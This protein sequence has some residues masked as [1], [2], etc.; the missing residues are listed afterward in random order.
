[1]A[2]SS[3]E[4]ADKYRDTMLQD[5]RSSGSHKIGLSAAAVGAMELV[6]AKGGPTLIAAVA[7]AAGAVTYSGVI[8]AAAHISYSDKV[9]KLMDRRSKRPK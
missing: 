4:K 9:D 7:A 6:V 1:M 2:W 3:R 8:T 5:V